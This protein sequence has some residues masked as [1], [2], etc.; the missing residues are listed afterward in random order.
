MRE[1]QRKKISFYAKESDVKVAYLAKQLMFVLL[2]KEACFNTNDLNPSLPSVVVSLLQDFEYVFPEDVPSG[3]PPIRGIEHHIDFI[4][5]V[6]IPINQ[7]IGVIQRRQ[8][9]F[10]S[11]LKS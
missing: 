11:K 5:G 8:W 4:L 6:A 1:K 7:P 9:N 10:K 3:L 2:Y